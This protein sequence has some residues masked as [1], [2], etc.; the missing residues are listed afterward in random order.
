MKGIATKLAAVMATI[1]HPERS[2]YVKYGDFHYATRDDIFECTRRALVENGVAWL[3]NM[4]RIDVQDTGKTTK[5]GDIIYR[6]SVEVGITFV[7]TDTGES[8][9]TVWAGESYA[10]DDRGSQA[11]A[12]Q[13]V[14][15]ALTN[16]FMLLDGFDVE[17]TSH[18][19]APKSVEGNTHREAAAPA[20]P[21]QAILEHLRGLE[22]SD[23]QI[24]LF[25]DF[26]AWQEDVEGIGDV[27]EA[28][29]RVWY[30][31]LAAKSD[32]EARDSVMD[33][34]KTVEA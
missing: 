8:C 22:F 21:T 28:R 3:P 16:T 25:G 19:T 24:G 4:R 34:I 23:D 12:T 2:E 1:E 18:Q 11:A 15:F 30:E 13:A 9:E 31:R 5:A 32:K 6:V 26:I 7:D 10:S 17:K 27:P 33:A 29:V 14:R 20:D